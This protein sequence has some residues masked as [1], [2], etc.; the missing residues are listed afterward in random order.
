MIYKIAFK[1]L[2]MEQLIE[3][4]K[5][6]KNAYTKCFDLILAITSNPRIGIGKPERLKGYGE[7]EAFSRRLNNKDRLVYIVF[8]DTETVEI[9]SCVGHYDDH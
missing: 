3:L 9:L 5:G 8:D 1:A 2:A 4:R 7:L 6:D